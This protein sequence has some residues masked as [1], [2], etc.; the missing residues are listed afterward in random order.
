MP[1]LAALLLAATLPGCATIKESRLSP[2]NWLEPRLQPPVLALYE[3]P[4]DPRPLV[5]EVT[6]LKVEPY[7]GGAIVRAT[8]VPATQGYW[9]AELVALPLDDKGQLVYEFRVIPPLVP[10]AAGTPF[11]RQITVATSISD[12]ALQDVRSIVVQGA[13]NALSSRR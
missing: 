1:I 12:I 6:V 4:E 11:V 13:G 8:G 10:A 9:E 7:P 2:L 5:A 3:R